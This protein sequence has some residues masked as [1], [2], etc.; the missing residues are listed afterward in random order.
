MR[1]GGGHGAGRGGE[2][3]DGGADWSL[4]KRL[5]SYVGAHKRLF[6]SALV[7]Y[8]IDAIAVVLPPYLVRQMLDVA[9]PARDTDLLEILALVYLT[10]LVVEYS[11]G[12]SAQLAMSV[13]GQRAMR[14]LRS[15]LFTH[16]QKLPARYFDQNPIG[17]VLTRLTND[18]EALGD[19]FATGAVTVLGDLITLIAVVSMMLWLDV[20]LTLFAFLVVPPLVVLVV[21]FRVF[22]RRAFRAILRRLAR[23]NTFLNEH[24]AGMSVVQIFRQQERTAAEF[25]RLNESY[26]D[27]NHTAIL[28]DALL[29]SIVEAI[30]TAAVAA[31]IWYGA[32]DLSTGLVGA[33]TLVAF[34]QYIRRFFIPIRDLSMKYTIIQSALAAAERCFQLLDEAITI[35]SPANA[36]P[37]AAVRHELAL[38][39]VWFSYRDPPTEADWVLRGLDLEVRRGERVALVGGTGSG[40]TTTLKLLNRFYDVQE[41]AVTVDGVDVRELELGELRRLFAVVLQ[42]VHLFT[43][44]VMDNLAFTDTVT[45]ADLRR[46]ARAVQLDPIVTRLPR[47]YRAKVQELGANFSAGERQ[48]FAFARAL[49]L[50]PEVL[51]LDEAT[52]NVDSET[53]AR[54]QAALAVLLEGRTAIIVAH[55]L[56]TIRKVDRIVVLQR[57]RA[58]E[59]GSHEQL[60]AR[61]GVY[62]RLVELQFNDAS[63]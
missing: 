32:V 6:V 20:R 45:E 55:R 30:G 36:R 12:F 44:T 47:G 27:A 28:Y 25:A 40:K 62:R 7:L 10:A 50:D 14:T 33:G 51:V 61:E 57:G 15:D 52:A 53:E 22:A 34:I 43:G 23:I 35:R 9:I 37:V 31:L 39:R 4:I 26:R 59:Q 3:I 17:R 21:I 29:F 49:A 5:L 48:L 19:V 2:R 8:P 1:F 60:M 41:G 56:S 24:I 13:L 11:T 42:D 63:A 18:V 46:A 16:V 38:R 58:V 54:I